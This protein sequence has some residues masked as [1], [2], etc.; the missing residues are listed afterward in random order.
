MQ[1]RRKTKKWYADIGM[2]LLLLGA[3]AWLALGAAA[4][5][6]EGLTGQFS[7]TVRIPAGLN[8]AGNVIRVQAS[9]P[10][11]GCVQD[12]PYHTGVCDE[13]NGGLVTG[14]ITNLGSNEP[15]VYTY[16]LEGINTDDWVDYRLSVEVLDPE[17]QTLYPAV[18]FVYDRTT[19]GESG[20]TITN[21]DWPN[22]NLNGV[23]DDAQPDPANST[24]LGPA[25]K[26]FFWD[27][28]SLTA[29][30]PVT[31]GTAG[32]GADFD[33]TAR[34]FHKISA[35]IQDSTGSLLEGAEMEVYQYGGIQPGE[36]GQW[37]RGY[38]DAS[39]GVIVWM[40]A[41]HT[42]GVNVQHDGLIRSLMYDGLTYN[43]D[44]DPG[45]PQVNFPADFTLTENIDLGTLSMDFA[46]NAITGT[47]DL[48]Y[49]ATWD[50]FFWVDA[51]APDGTTCEGGGSF[52]GGTEFRIAAGETTGTFTI[53]GLCASPGYVLTLFIGRGMFQIASDIDLSSGDH[54]FEENL[55]LD[56]LPVISGT[57]TV[58]EAITQN[59]DVDV[60][61]GAEDTEN[62]FFSS[63]NVYIPQGQTT[64][65]YTLMVE[66]GA[67]YH[68]FAET[69]SEASQQPVRLYYATGGAV[70]D[71]ADATPVAPGET[72]DIVIS[73]VE[74]R[75]ISGTI[76]G[77]DAFIDQTLVVEAWSAENWGWSMV[78]IVVDSA[79]EVYTI[80]NLPPQTDYQVQVRL[81]DDWEVRRFWTDDGSA[82]KDGW[83]CDPET[84]ECTLV[85]ETLLDLGAGDRS[86]MDIN[87]EG[88]GGANISGTITLPASW[89]TA[90]PSGLNVDA[91]VPWIPWDGTGDDPN[92][93]YEGCWGSGIWIDI[94]DPLPEINNDGTYSIPYTLK[95]LCDTV[96]Y[97]VHVWADGLGE[98]FYDSTPENMNHVTRMSWDP[99]AN[100]GMGGI[101]AS[102]LV[103]APATGI[104][105]TL[106][107][108]IKVGGTLTFTGEIV[109]A[110]A[111]AEVYVD[112][113]VPWE[114]C[115]QD[116]M[117][118]GAWANYTIT[119]SSDPVALPYTLT[120]LD[121]ADYQ[122]HIGISFQDASGNWKWIDG[123]C[124]DN[125]GSYGFTRQG[126]DP[127]ANN[128]MGAPSEAT[129]LQVLEGGLSNVDMVIGKGVDRSISGSITLPEA[130][131]TDGSLWVDAWSENCGVGNGFELFYAMGDT[132][133]SYV[134]DG[135]LSAEGYRVSVSGPNIPWL[136]YAG[137]PDGA[138]DAVTND[139]NMATP[140]DLRTEDKGS[141]DFSLSTGR[142]ISG[143]VNITSG[144]LP[145]LRVEAWSESTGAWREADV[146]DGGFVLTDLPPAADYRISLHKV[147]NCGDFECFEYLG[148]YHADATDGSN[149]DYRWDHWTPADITSADRTGIYFLLHGEAGFDIRII[150]PESIAM[151]GDANAW[152]GWL[153]VNSE[154]ANIWRGNDA[155]QS[156]FTRNG[157]KWEAV[158]NVTVPEGTNGYR[159]GF[160]P[161]WQ[162]NLPGG[163]FAGNADGSSP[164]L[165]PDWMKATLLDPAVLQG[166]T[167]VLE[168]T[169]GENIVV[170]VSVP[171]RD[172]LT[173]PV[174]ISAWSE[175]SG[176][177]GW[178]EL[179]SGDFGEDDQAV[180]TIEGLAAAPDYRLEVWSPDLGQRYYSGGV[181]GIDDAQT[182]KWEEATLLDPSNAG[183]DTNRADIV[184]A[185]LD[186]NA[187]S[188]TISIDP[189]PENEIYMWVEAYNADWSA[190]DGR[191]VTIGPGENSATY[192][193]KLPPATNDVPAT[194]YTVQVWAG[195]M[196]A[197]ADGTSTG[198]DNSGGPVGNIDFTLGSGHSIGGTVT[199]GGSFVADAWVDAFDKNKGYFVGGSPSDSSGNYQ[200]GGL[201][202]GDYTL[203]VW[204]P[205][206][207][208]QSQDVTVD[209]GDPAGV[210]FVLAQGTTLSGTVENADGQPVANADVN[211]FQPNSPQ[212]F[213][214]MSDAGGRFVIAG[215]G[216]GETY[217]L[218]VWAPGYPLHETDVIAGT[219]D[220]ITVTL[221]TGVPVTGM[222]TLQDGGTIPPGSC[223]EIWDGIP[224]KSNLI[225]VPPL[226]VNGQMTTMPLTAGD[227]TFVYRV[228]GYA[229][230]E[231]AVNIDTG[232]IAAGSKLVDQTLAAIVKAVSGNVQ[233]GSTEG[234]TRIVILLIDEGSGEAVVLDTETLEPL[235]SLQPFNFIVGDGDYIVK[236]K[237]VNDDLETVV[238]D[239]TLE[240]GAAGS[241]TGNGG[242]VADSFS[243]QSMP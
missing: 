230:V 3:A 229:V 218:V 198:I 203:S 130:A 233:L 107:E 56:N 199:A 36:Q 4:A 62:G 112:A 143:R 7:G 10:S 14:E 121:P 65:D 122:L 178:K 216:S 126:W 164:K 11:L 95:G 208:A 100:G 189:A 115:G 142:S 146:A 212:G 20:E 2:R 151:P 125:E 38:S 15:A 44:L 70:M 193:M 161:D 76:A 156:A 231:G 153:D 51:E 239:I 179:S 12:D 60:W 150:L 35:T 209:G 139:W 34:T 237:A 140:L 82:V 138:V 236:A 171:D 118:S 213:W 168:V 30:H 111:T 49:P 235:T 1:T 25:L 119:G 75:S 227:Y 194:H 19:T 53:K 84:W 160:W 54:V 182:M 46:G 202:D 242:V 39:G 116:A 190:Y 214:A 162:I 238:V 232:D 41:G 102:C 16:S 222:V 188:G 78:T 17:G 32:G 219:D 81:E 5:S 192:S 184:F 31:G 79:T 89:V 18:Y 147:A 191:Q 204:T 226:G 22:H 74:G 67:A 129:R 221:T 114:W 186:G 9:S 61:V 27:G 98:F 52:W 132:E 120:G 170:S 83:Q 187:V 48:G 87:M 206:Y 99:E 117:T 181:D 37:G 166:N 8:V 225:E 104:D 66:E 148:H 50:M 73:G 109:P 105:M 169:S 211:V 28:A 124:E 144:G 110:G 94:P 92:T 72:A 69:W 240:G 196:V 45:D 137:S 243:S 220:D 223:V 127:T 59:H 172:A 101:K 97:Q 133:L 174:F 103:I 149:L 173:E 175:S 57:I 13:F 63:T 77:L 80:S 158:F 86:G 234:V 6:A 201:A 123:F 145:P 106:G 47:I 23:P 167:I 40:P 183:L 135:L 210:N 68:L 152:V 163:F 136:C 157:D 88:A 224:G 91:W 93:Q 58:P 195:D 197:S 134:I 90:N 200:I 71:V 42:Y 228:P 64:G 177:W 96:D 155:K 26:L 154:Q 21:W 165:N 85:E 29:N 141:I 205:D 180:F 215:L 55:L 33:L 108:G 43:L 241:A 113:W 185:S 159:I 207:A 217:R 131:P 128:G 176:G 24:P